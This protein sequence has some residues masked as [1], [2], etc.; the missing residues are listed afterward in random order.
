M[1]CT[2]CAEVLVRGSSSIGVSGSGTPTDP[3]IIESEITDFEGVLIVS[4]TDSVNLNLVGSG[5]L[6]DPFRLS[7]TATIAVG[8]LTDIIDPSGPSIGDVITYMGSH[9]EF[10]PPP[11]TPAGAVNVSN[12]IGGVGSVG[13]PLTLLVAAVWGTGELAG[14]GADST[15]GLPVYVDSVGKVRAKPVTALAYGSLTG[16]PSTFAPAAHNQ[17]YT[18]ITNLSDLASVSRVDGRKVNIQSNST[19]PTPD[20]PLH[21]VLFPKGS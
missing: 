21:V 3:F 4:D 14:L 19:M 17:S 13:T 1:P 6:V 7:A 18:T 8:E 11:V 5:T 16:V 12:G 20:G 9:F 10:A 2:D 15:I